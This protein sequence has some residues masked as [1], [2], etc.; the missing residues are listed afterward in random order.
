MVYSIGYFF[1]TNIEK[2]LMEYIIRYGLF[3][4]FTFIEFSKLK[5]KNK[6]EYKDYFL[7]DWLQKSIPLN[8][9]Y[10]YI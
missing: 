1:P 5:E 6:E 4:I 8:E 3:V 7:Y 2:S 10:K 9:M